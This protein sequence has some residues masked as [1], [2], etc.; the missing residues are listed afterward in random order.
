M[1]DSVTT[2]ASSAGQN[3][4]SSSKRP[5]PNL[6]S[7]SPL[8]LGNWLLQHRFVEKE[9]EATNFL[10]E[11]ARTIPNAEATTLEKLAVE[12]DDEPKAPTAT[13]LGRELLQTPEKALEVSLLVPR[14]KAQVS[15][16]AAGMF[17]ED[18]KKQESFVLASGS[19]ERM[20]VFPKPQDCQPSKKV[21]TDMVLLLLQPSTVCCYKK[22][23][24][25]QVCL[26]LPASLP[27]W[28]A[29]DD[30]DDD[31]DWSNLDHSDQ[32]TRVFSTSLGLSTDQISRIINPSSSADTHFWKWQ[33]ESYESDEYSTTTGGMPFVSCHCGVQDG[34]LFPMPEG[35]LFFKPPR[36]VP[37]SALHSIACG[38]RH[39][40]GSSRYVDLSVVLDAEEHK[41]LEFTNIH[42]S[43]LGV[44]RNYIH[45]T[46]IPAMEK[47]AAGSH[48]TAALSDNDVEET[49]QA[50][51]SSSSQ[52]G[53]G[54]PGKRKASVEARAVTKRMQ[55]ESD[56]EEEEEADDD[57]VWG[58][59][60]NEDE[61]DYDDDED[62]EDDDDDEEEDVE[63]D[64][65]EIESDPNGDKD[66]PG[67]ETE[68][69][70]EE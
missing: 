46:L 68:S 38:P 23:T 8:E 47:D 2:T 57:Y 25:Q 51:S 45:Q 61:E 12:R 48:V 43:E 53:D 55:V 49:E 58:A 20:I 22:K 27:E 14:V 62:E 1:S 10:L 30:D 26:Q 41:E 67:E 42:R 17:F 28:N 29:S 54:R 24:L 35:L 31:D 50:L 5:Y 36:F 13:D 15:W 63:D 19:V 33:F 11:A 64:D 52:S 37:R 16:H 39:G 65:E 7:C 69:E 9:M 66:L 60:M 34:V 21:P 3:G 40:G 70:D 6:Q 59:N 44:L 18:K 4:V 32:W 56:G